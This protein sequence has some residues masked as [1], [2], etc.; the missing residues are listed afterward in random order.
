M[1]HLL[2]VHREEAALQLSQEDL[3]A[4]LETLRTKKLINVG[5]KFEIILHF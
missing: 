2:S 5:T 3:A 4:I 1:E